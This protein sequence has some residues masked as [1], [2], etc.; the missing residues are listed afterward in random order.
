M[1]L[2]WSRWFRC[3]SSF[4][5]LLVPR[6]PGIF[7]LAEEVGEAS[8]ML[9]VFE[10]GEADDVGRSLSRLFSPA[11]PWRARLTDGRCYLRYAIV[12]DTA[13]RRAAAATL[14]NWLHSQMDTAAQLFEQRIPSAEVTVAER[15]VDRVMKK[16]ELAKAAVPAGF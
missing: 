16:T 9:A 8:R 3:E 4:G 15:A 13:H 14:K 12:P 11:S 2:N 7:A 1:E 5:L 6:Q 10:I